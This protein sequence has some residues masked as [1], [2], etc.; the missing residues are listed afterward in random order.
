M[1]NNI[2]KIIAIG[3]YLPNKII[4]ND[5]L[6]KDLNTDDEWIRSRTGIGQRHIASTKETTSFM[7][8]Q[9]ANNALKEANVAPDQ[10]D[11]IIVA[12]TTANKIFPSVAAEVGAILG[13]NHAPAFDLQAVCS[14]FLY[15]YVTAVNMMQANP[16]LNHILVIGSE[17]MSSI[18]DW[19]D[20]GSCIL[21]GDGAGAVLLARD[22]NNQFGYI[23]SILKADG[24]LADI[25]YANSITEGLKMNGRA[26]FANATN[27]LAE[28]TKE[29]CLKNKIEIEEIDH[30]VIHQANIRIL[31]FL[32]E[33][34][35]ID[36]KKMPASIEKHA[37]TSAASIP[38]LLNE[39]KSSIKKGDL[40]LMAA[41]GA[42]FT[43][44]AALL[45]F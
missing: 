7:A 30:F 2:I 43:W 22:Q 5:E 36:P 24:G 4:T 10:V 29:L 13:C 25:L 1:K 39:Y 41:A 8:S 42:G 14:G 12:T 19:N 9:A 15:G 31:Q 28:V 44:G 37:N 11:L 33:K 20:R 26:V 32:A 34:L 45:R 16:N 3:G 18:V 40:I 21:F 6:S 35:K 23:D 38:L 27:K 17:R